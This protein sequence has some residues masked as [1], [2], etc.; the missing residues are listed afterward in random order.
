MIYFV[1][2][3]FVNYFP[4]LYMYIMPA[5]GVVMYT[6]AYI[7]WRFSVKYYKSTGN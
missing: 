4:A 5:I 6:G 7:F 2:F 1:P 3:A